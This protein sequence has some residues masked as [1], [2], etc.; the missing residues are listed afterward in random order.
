MTL[1]NII[2]LPLS[3]KSDAERLPT[4]LQTDMLTTRPYVTTYKGAYKPPSLWQSGPACA[5][6]YLIQSSFILN[7]SWVQ[8]APNATLNSLGSA[9][10]HSPR[11]RSTG[12]TVLNISEIQRDS[13]E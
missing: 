5:V 13:R 4:V 10:T 6:L 11:V 3:F 8:I 1:V 2:H 9:A 12:R 7:M